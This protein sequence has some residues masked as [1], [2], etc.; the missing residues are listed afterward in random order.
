MR[1]DKTLAAI[2][3]AND[4]SRA[5]VGDDGSSSLS[6]NT[7][8]VGPLFRLSL[9]QVERGGPYDWDVSFETTI[10][11]GGEHG[12]IATLS[13][14][15]DGAGTAIDGVGLLVFGGVGKNVTM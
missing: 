8:L 3:N 12:F 14:F 15:F 6:G 10:R 13:G 11:V 1:D 7:S 4:T 2:R 9:T 5:N